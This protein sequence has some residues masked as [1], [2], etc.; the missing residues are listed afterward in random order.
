VINLPPDAE[1]A[2][3]QPVIILVQL[4]YL[5]FPSGV[6]ALNTSTWDLEWAGVTYKGAYGLGSISAIEDV[7]QAINGLKFTIGG[8]YSERISL[9]LDDADEWQ[10]SE[11]TI[12]TAILNDQYQVVHAEIDWTGYGDTLG[13]QETIDAS[14][15]EAT[16]ESSA[17]DLLKSNESTYSDSTQRVIDPS[18]GAF[19]YIL[20]QASQ[21]V[22][23]PAR[24][25]YQR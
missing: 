15:I 2:L 21:P 24:S 9:A 10:G 11:V 12:R 3:Q 1:S 6:V 16:A 8:V 14:T 4:L 17:V 25:F 18:D 20:S 23:W 7:P 22:I 19:Q 13:I 5:G